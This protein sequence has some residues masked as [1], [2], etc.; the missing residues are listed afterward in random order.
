MRLSI[1]YTPYKFVMKKNEFDNSDDDEEKSHYSS[2][3]ENFTDTI[4]Y[5]RDTKTFNTN[6]NSK[7][8]KE[9]I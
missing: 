6:K 2:F 4:L 7:N 3:E 9:E 5:K 8:N 1:D